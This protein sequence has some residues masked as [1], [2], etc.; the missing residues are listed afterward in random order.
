M[1]SINIQSKRNRYANNLWES[2]QANAVMLTYMNLTKVIHTA[3]GFIFRKFILLNGDPIFQ[4]AINRYTSYK[5]KIY[6]Q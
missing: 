1:L 3:P 4:S 5:N 2:N 6:L